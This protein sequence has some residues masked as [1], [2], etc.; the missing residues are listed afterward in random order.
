M[1]F[2]GELA[3]RCEGEFME[4]EEEQLER[5]NDGE[6]FWFFFHDPSRQ[7]SWMFE[8]GGRRFFPKATPQGWSLKCSD[9]LIKWPSEVVGRL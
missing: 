5:C 8:I 6:I 4:I 9:S 3:A 2:R 1:A 7:I